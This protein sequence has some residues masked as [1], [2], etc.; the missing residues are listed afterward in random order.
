MV[1]PGPKGPRAT[2][3]LA[4]KIWNLTSLKSSVLEVLRIGFYLSHDLRLEILCISRSRISG[5]EASKMHQ[6]VR[7][8][9]AHK[10]KVMI[11][12]ETHIKESDQLRIDG[13]V[14]IHSSDEVK[15][16]KGKPKQTSTGATLVLH[17]SVTGSVS[18]IVPFQGAFYSLTC[19]PTKCLPQF[20]HL[21][22]TR[23]PSTR[24]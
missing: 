14:F 8:M 13:H 24:N 2:T 20:C 11:L 3:L 16:G 5:L 18:R 4:E 6:V 10:L 15:D 17:H 22:T 9:K 7:H 21:R 12:E 19:G 1:G 23:W